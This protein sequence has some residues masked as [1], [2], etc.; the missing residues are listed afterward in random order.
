MKKILL[1]LFMLLV[2][3]LLIAV[4]PTEADAAIYDDT[5][6]LHILAPSDSSEDQALKLSI[7]DK[8]L[9]KYSESLGG[10]ADI[11]YAKEKVLTSLAEIE[12]DCNRWIAEAGYS[13]KATAQLCEEWYNTREYKDFSLP[14]GYY[15]S[16]KITIGEGEGANWWCVMYP[17]MCLDIATE[18]AGA[19]YSEEEYRLISP[20]GY[21]IKFKTL[22]LFSELTRCRS[23]KADK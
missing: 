4:I 8:L 6:R 3:T 9:E 21:R 13:Y 12:R 19:E 16:L 18:A 7:R 2:S 11:L 14:Q 5:I 10:A 1:P 17:P 20:S 22:E 23:Y 15:T